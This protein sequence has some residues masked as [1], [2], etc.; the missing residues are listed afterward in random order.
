ME[1]LALRRP[2]L[3]QRSPLCEARRLARENGFVGSRDYRHV[4][5]Y[6]RGGRYCS[7]RLLCR[8][9]LAVRA[10]SIGRRIACGQAESVYAEVNL[11]LAS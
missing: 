2:H 11:I 5:Q 8:F 10:I 7:P 6:V 9:D 4:L 1:T 3:G